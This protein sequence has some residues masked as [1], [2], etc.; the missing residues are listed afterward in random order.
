MFAILG[1]TGNVGSAAAKA[2]REKGAAV[3]AIVHD[4]KKAGAL[5]DAGCEVVM[6]DLQDTSSL[7]AAIEGADA[8][9]AIVPLRPSPEPRDDMRRTMQSLVSAFNLAKPKRLLV[10][11]DY[12]AHVEHDI[13]M[14]SMF[15]DFEAMLQQLDGHKIILRSAEYMHNW[16]RG[17]PTAITS[18]VLPSFQIP[19]TMLQPTIA[20]QDTGRIASDLLMQADRGADFVV[21]HAEGPRRYSAD[22][23]A[24]AVSQLSGKSIKAQAVPRS[25]WNGAFANMPPSLADLLVKANDAKNAGGLVDAA[26]GGVVRLG[27]TELIDGLRP[28]VPAP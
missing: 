25:E 28:F 27:L 22:D 16:G 15:H 12:G 9:Q 26:P 3:R 6:A 21:V 19:V 11:S 13:G 10:I 7:T 17:I 14:P 5:R 23:V 8:V 1:A 18:G 24:A 20:A 2:L 4:E